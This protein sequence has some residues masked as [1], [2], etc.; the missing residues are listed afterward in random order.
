MKKTIL[1]FALTLILSNLG[2]SQ[3]ILFLK[4]GDKMNGKLDGYK[5]DTIIF[6]LQGN[7][8]KFKTSDIISIYFDEKLA[9]HDIGN[10]PNEMKPTQE[11]KIFGVVTYFFNDNYGDKPDVGAMVCIV[12]SAKFP[13]FNLATV[14]T[15]QHANFYKNIYLDYK[16]MG[17]GKVPNDVTELVKKYNIEDKT[18]FDSLDHRASKN[19]FRLIYTK[20]VMKTVVNG[21]GSYSI[22][23]KPGTYYV[24]IKSN[25]RKYF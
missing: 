3:N 20:D 15:F 19:I 2:F 16:S 8:L 9:P 18:A 13:E 10:N 5:N 22:K 6:E 23:V 21:S 12:D 4:N 1:L 7:K 17:N 24:C 11:G 25:N 14:D